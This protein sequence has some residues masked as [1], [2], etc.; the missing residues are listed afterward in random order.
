MNS[1]KNNK[2]KCVCVNIYAKC[3]SNKDDCDEVYWEK[4]DYKK[5]KCCVNVNI[6]ADCGKDKDW[7]KKSQY[8]HED[9]CCVEVNLF[10]DCEK[11]KKQP[12]DCCED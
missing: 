2:D 9:D 3:N 8:N 7:S 11:S 6:F 4:Q 10:T 1:S 12:Y 5:E